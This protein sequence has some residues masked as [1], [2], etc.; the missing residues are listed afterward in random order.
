MAV[1]LKPAYVFL[2]GGS[3]L[4]IYLVTQ[5]RKDDSPGFDEGFLAGWVSPGPITIAAA[6][7][8]AIYFWG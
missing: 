4:A 6:V 2:I 8:G 7:G 1:F 3:L 5:K